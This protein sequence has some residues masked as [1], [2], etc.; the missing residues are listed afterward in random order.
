[1]VDKITCR[2]FN[3]AN[4]KWSDIVRC[5]SRPKLSSALVRALI[6]KKRID[7]RL[8]FKLLDRNRPNDYEGEY[9]LCSAVDKFVGERFQI[10][11]RSGSMNILLGNEDG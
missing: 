11:V 6:A 7:N 9:E 5:G 3:F 1:M 4:M 2:V 10:V 8:D